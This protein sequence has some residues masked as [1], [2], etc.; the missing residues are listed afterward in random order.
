MADNEVR[1]ENLT[2]REFREALERGEYRTAIVPTGAIEQHLDHLPMGHDIGTCTAIA[3]EVARRLYPSVIVAVPMC[4]GISEHHMIHPGTVTAKPGSWL[5][6]LFDADASLVRHGIQNVLILNGHGGNE[7]PVYGMIRQ[8]QLFF[9]SSHP[10]SNVQFQSYW[11]LSREDAE[12]VCEARVPGHA[13]EYET[14]TH[15]AMFPGN[16]REDAMRDQEDK[17][18]LDASAEKGEKLV[19]AAIA[20]TVTYLE[21]MMAGEHH[22][23]ARH[24]FSAESAPK[25]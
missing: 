22:D 24:V 23:V 6:V 9:G 25:A 17:Q 3:E 14:S 15:Y 20:R 2:R 16:I 8:W 18:P 19:E 13:G 1:I 4:V 11:N 7:M 5:A 12:A 21:E 10:G